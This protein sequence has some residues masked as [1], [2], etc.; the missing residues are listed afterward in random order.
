MGSGNSSTLEAR[1]N[2][3]DPTCCHRMGRRGAIQLQI[4]AGIVTSKVVNIYCVGYT[5]VP[6]LTPLGLDLV[7]YTKI[8]INF[9]I[10]SAL[11]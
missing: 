6:D 1:S 11:S 9:E 10:E 4:N 3:A 5:L 2:A 8:S 7:L